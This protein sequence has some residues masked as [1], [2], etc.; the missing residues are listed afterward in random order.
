MKIQFLML[1]KADEVFKEV[2]F[3]A[4]LERESGGHVLLRYRPILDA[5]QQN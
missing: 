3:L 1:G 5:G 2:K 4:F